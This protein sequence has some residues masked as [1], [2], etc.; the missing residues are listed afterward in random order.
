MRA[1]R[2]TVVSTAIISLL[3]LAPLSALSQSEAPA[4]AQT[5]GCTGILELVGEPGAEVMNW[6]ST[7]PRLSGEVTESG[8]WSMYGPPSEDAG[9]ATEEAGSYIIINDD[10]SWDCVDAKP[11]A[12]EPDVNT[13]TLVFAGTGAYEGLTAHVR[14][15]WSTYPFSFTG[16]IIE[17][18]APEDTMLQ[19]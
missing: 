9:S 12:P 16:V 8:G 7:D 5:E 13:D 4:E 19:G 6:D 1:L 14:I 11:D 2:T 17:G 10:G 15:D 18:A 3:A